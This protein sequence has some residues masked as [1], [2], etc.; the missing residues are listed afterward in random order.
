MDTLEFLNICRD[1]STCMVP[2]KAHETDAGY[3]VYAD[4]NAEI[5]P[6][7]RKLISTGIRIC[8]PENCYARVAPRS[9]LS[10]KGIDIGAGVIDCSYTGEIKVLM[11]NNTDAMY[12]IKK[13][14]KI[15]QLILERIMCPKIHVVEKCDYN[16]NTSRRDAGFGSSDH[17]SN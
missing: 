10:C 3:D 4:E 14:D 5:Q 6:W 13:G 17:P 1:T 9:G 12:A 2:T 16:F 7:T 15:A 8:I 11:I